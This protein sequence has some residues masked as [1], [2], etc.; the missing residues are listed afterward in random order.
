MYGSP[1]ILIVNSSMYENQLYML[2][3]KLC[4]RI[5]PRTRIS[6]TNAM[7]M[8]I[9]NCRLSHLLCVCW[10]C[11]FLLLLLP[12]LPTTTIQNLNKLKKAMG[13][14]NNIWQPPWMLSQ[15]MLSSPPHNK[16]IE[17]KIKQKMLIHKS[18]NKWWQPQRPL[19]THKKTNNAREE[20]NSLWQK[21]SHKIMTH[22]THL[23][24]NDMTTLDWL[25]KEDYF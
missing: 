24:Q 18:G 12:Q 9:G 23:N 22:C 11:R 5:A 19:P 2:L 10:C 17:I 14:P 3:L 6:I 21:C 4:K 13:S 16:K 7:C 8:L 25:F 15:E 1:K 20:P